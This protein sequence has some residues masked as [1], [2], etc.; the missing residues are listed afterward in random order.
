MLS[1]EKVCGVDCAR[2]RELETPT[3]D[4]ADENDSELFSSVL[5]REVMAE[6]VVEAEVERTCE[7]AEPVDERDR[8]MGRAAGGDA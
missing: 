2:F 4:S 8:D 6:S 1:D 5:K 7:L 3:C